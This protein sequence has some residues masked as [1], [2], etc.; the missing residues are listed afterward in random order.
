MQV[1]E[2]R[3][4]SLDAVTRTRVTRSESQLPIGK[5]IKGA[6]VLQ[7]GRA[8]TFVLVM[9]NTTDKEFH[10]FATP[11][12]PSP[13]EASIGYLFECLC[14][15]HVFKIASKSIWYRVVRLELNEN[16][17]TPKSS[18]KHTLVGVPADEVGVKYKKV[19]FNEN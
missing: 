11:H 6:L 5:E 3:D 10:F 12:I 2:L 17:S 8:R 9:R 13:P 18:L 16:F 19:I 14:N 15:S 7:P 4:G 1:Y